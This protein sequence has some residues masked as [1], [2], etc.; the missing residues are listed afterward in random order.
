MILVQVIFNTAS[1][2]EETSPVISFFIIYLIPFLTGWLIFRTPAVASALQTRYWNV[3]QRTF[4]AEVIS[5]NFVL[6]GAIPTLLI[7]SNWYPDFFGPASPPTYLLLSLA[8]TAGALISYPYQIWMVNRGYHVWS[9]RLK[10]DRSPT[11]EGGQT[12]TPRISNAWVIL[13][14]S[15]VIFLAS[16][17][18]TIKSLI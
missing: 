14:L 2:M 16:F 8:V 10:I 3:I 5:V 7:P 1:F 9:I 11:Q 18:L 4:L 6:S 12:M 13:G 17:V 15:I